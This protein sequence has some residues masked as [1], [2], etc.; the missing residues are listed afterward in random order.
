MVATAVPSRP[1]PVGIL[2]PSQAPRWVPCA[3]SFSLEAMFPDDEDSPEAREGT[4]AHYYVT[5]AL[6][7]RFHPAGT[8]APNGYPLD[9]DMID[10]GELYLEDVRSTFAT[11]PQDQHTIFRVEQKVFAHTLIHPECEGTPD[12]WAANFNVGRLILWDYKY[13]HKYVEP[14]G[15]WQ[16]IGYLAGI[17][18]GLGLSRQETWNLD[19]SVRVIQ[20]RNYHR[21]GP[22]REWNTTGATIWNYIDRMKTAAYA[23]KDPRATTQTGPQCVD[24]NGRH[25]CEAFARVAAR[26]L[27]VA[28][29]TIPQELP[30]MALGMELRRIA[31]AI[32][33][34]E[35]RRDGLAEQ[36]MAKIR[37]GTPVPFWTMGFV[38]ARERWTVPV[39][40]VRALGELFGKKLTEE[41]PITPAQ[42]RKLGIDAA[43][44][45]VY[46][47][48][49]TGAAK[50][51]PADETA[52]AKA[53]GK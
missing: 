18:E 27:D 11:L 20:P 19:V 45:R 28:G 12:T 32:K 22:V 46:S 41:K 1:L 2:R 49:P 25:A 33:R 6:Q 26:A 3:G 42:A 38:D 48:K 10:H 40:E 7:G 16:F 30:P 51:V 4:A 34:L 8:L 39:A 53:F 21:D 47:A 52:A 29:E 31:D 14:F 17:F 37:T 15:N 23:A 5:E 50:L 13:G 44:I 24:C 35:A 43:V 36:A 9:G